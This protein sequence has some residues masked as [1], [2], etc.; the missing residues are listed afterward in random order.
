VL[1][2][3]RMAWASRGSAKPLTAAVYRQSVCDNT[4]SASADCSVRGINE[5][6]PDLHWHKTLSHH[7]TTHCIQLTGCERERERERERVLLGNLN[8]VHDGG[9]Q[10]AVHSP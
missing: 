1:A 8:N 4:M 7:H 9:V 2:R 3:R 10:G 5:N 6:K